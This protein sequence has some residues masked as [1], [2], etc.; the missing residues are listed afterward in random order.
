[1]PLS[2]AT[3]R[4]GGV[5]LADEASGAFA[6][7]YEY[8]CR[9]LRR[10]GVRRE[11]VEDLAQ[12]VFVV[13]CRRWQ[14]YDQ[15]RPLRAW[16]AGIAF[17]VAQKHS[18]RQWREAPAGEVEIVDE[19]PQPDE[20]LHAARAG[21]VVL[22]ALGS[23][24]PNDR[25]V[26]VL[27][28]I[29]ELPMQ[30]VAAL[31]QVPRFTAYTRLRRARLRFAQK[32]ADLQPGDR[33]IGL[34]LTA[35]ALLE[36]ERR[37][38]PGSPEA[39]SRARAL[40]RSANLGKLVPEA[41]AAAGLPAFWP[42]AAALALIA[43]LGVST[44]RT[45]ASRDALPAVL[46]DRADPTLVGAW[47]FEDGPGSL[48][49]RDRS[50]AHRDCVLRDLDPERSWIPGAT[51]GAL[52]MHRGWLEC[53]Q[54]PSTV[55]AST[56]LTV[57]ARVKLVRAKPAALMALVTRQLARDERDYFFFGIRDGRLKVRSSLWPHGL[58]TQPPFPDDRWVAVAF[59]HAADGTTRLFQDGRL[60]LEVQGNH[61]TERTE[62]VTP[63]VIG[64]GITGPGEERLGQHLSGSID[65]VAIYT[66]ALRPEEIAALARA[67]NSGGR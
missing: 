67:A 28:Q 49:V 15:S 53:P 41:P 56:E 66:R 27:H 34:P 30:E 3:A 64:A 45:R 61:W 59:T 39:R 42:A 65:E 22:T 26:L 55:R 18:V 20:R 44:V 2:D 63:I 46:G 37:Q 31:L 29:D 16:L 8:L 4:K 36:L 40:M 13:M 11:D 9:A 33:A 43:A 62:L 6:E 58:E 57:M 25:A 35:E 5:P 12:D 24:P 1:M 23:M 10:F 17:N 14:S 32:V 38:L 50:R 54:P 52:R 19:A 47:S 60:V 7:H 21:Q 48:V 51:G